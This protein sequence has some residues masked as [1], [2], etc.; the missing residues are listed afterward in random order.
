MSYHKSKKKGKDKI[1]GVSV[2]A[3]TILISQ[4]ISL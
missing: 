4:D 3:V 2:M 1:S